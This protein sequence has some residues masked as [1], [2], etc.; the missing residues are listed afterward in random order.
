MSILRRRI[1]LIED[2]VAMGQS[3][4][5]S[6]SPT[7]SVLQNLSPTKAKAR[8]YTRL[9]GTDERPPPVHKSSYEMSE[10]IESAGTGT[11]ITAPGLELEDSSS[12]S[13][14][15]N[16]TIVRNVPVTDATR[17]LPFEDDSDSDE[18]LMQGN[19][20]RS[21]HGPGGT[22]KNKKQK[23]PS[24]PQESFLSITLQIFFPFLIA[25]MG[26]VGAGLV[27]DVVQHWV[28]PSL[29]TESDA[30]YLHTLKSISF[31]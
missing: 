4:S 9:S 5:S 6:P 1:S 30:A 27:L 13:L 12:E 16:D 10:R 21:G 29:L 28:S 11:S 22:N 7:A 14:T 24:M 25:G 20:S 15:D 8:P 2:C 31:F 3:Q 17:L 18:E 23:T 26:M 19:N